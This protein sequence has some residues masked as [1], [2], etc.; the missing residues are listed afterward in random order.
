MNRLTHKISDTPVSAGTMALT[1]ST[2]SVRPVKD[3]QRVFNIDPSTSPTPLC[4]GLHVYR[5]E[6]S[7]TGSDISE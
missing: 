3:R 2:H 6:N 5:G 1:R 4:G 7:E